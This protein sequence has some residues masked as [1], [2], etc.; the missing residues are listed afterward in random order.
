MILNN[1][2]KLDELLSSNHCDSL[3]WNEGG[4]FELAEE[5]LTDFDDSDWN[6]LTASWQGKNSS[7]K[8]CLAALLTPYYG[9]QAQE[10]IIKMANNN[11]PEVA[12]EAMYAISFY[13]GINEN[14][15]GLYLDQE[16]VH[17]EFKNKL[18]NNHQFIDSISKIEKLVGEKFTLLKE[19]LNEIL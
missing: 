12:M 7:W 13:C 14:A 5:I 19:I 4:Q 1:F 6:A 2:N 15:D 18:L 9:S 3:K 8:R 17:L 10:I 16:I 11:N